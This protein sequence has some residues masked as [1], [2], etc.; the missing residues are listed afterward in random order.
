MAFDMVAFAIE[1]P[2]P[3]TILLISSDPDLAYA[4]STLRNYKYRVVVLCPSG[5][6]EAQADAH[7]D[8]DMEVLGESEGVEPSPT[9]F[10]HSAPRRQHHAFTGGIM[11]FDRKGKGNDYGSDTNENPHLRHDFSD[12]RDHDRPSRHCRS[13]T[14]S[15]PISPAASFRSAQSMPQTPMH[16]SRE[17]ESTIITNGNDL[18][19]SSPQPA[20]PDDFPF[21]GIAHT[22]EPLTL[23]ET[24]AE[25][26][27]PVIQASLPTTPVVTTP[28]QAQIV[29]TSTVVSKPKPESKL[30]TPS[31]TMTSSKPPITPAPSAA[32]GVAQLGPV[33][34]HFLPL[35]QAL[36]IRAQAKEVK[37]LRSD[38]GS[39]LAKAAKGDLK[40][41]YAQAKVTKFA[42]Y[43]LLAVDAGVIQVGGAGNQAW[44]SLRPEWSSSNIFR[45]TTT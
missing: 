41:I 4:M 39:D 8:W 42:S 38:I 37:V 24:S 33:S 14:T 23:V 29:A 45:T 44:V 32:K 10:G 34:S 13:M 36:Q 6:L 1:H 18:F 11:P 21:A 26:K 16:D 27:P 35:I 30:L 9:P 43:M 25:K 31:T 3:A 28:P 40:K 12:H 17:V 20:L 5:S 2:T 15:R 19:K 22:N 7:F